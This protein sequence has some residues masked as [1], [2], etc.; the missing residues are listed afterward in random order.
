MCDSNQSEAFLNMLTRRGLLED[1][2]IDDNKVRQAEKTKKRNMYHNTQLMLKHY[3]DINWALECFPEGVAEELDRPLH[4]LD[5]LLS[6]INTELGMG[7][8]KLENRLMSIQR[9]R[10]LLDRVN[11]ALT[12]LR[13]KPGNG[14]LMYQSLYLSYIAPETV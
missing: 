7:N 10:L 12:V 8:A 4:N 1:P 2:E 14:E 11:E 9:S 13:H 5:S 3:R 6:L